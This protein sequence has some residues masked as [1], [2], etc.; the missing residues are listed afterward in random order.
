[1]DVKYEMHQENITV[2]LVLEF[3]LK[4]SPYKR[5]PFG[6]FESGFFAK[7]IP[8]PNTKDLKYFLSKE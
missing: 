2:S 7:N 5:G 3:F 8:K 1:M 4:E 6:G